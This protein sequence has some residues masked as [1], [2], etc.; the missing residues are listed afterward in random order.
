V[1]EP[2]DEALRAQLDLPEGQGAVVTRVLPG[3]VAEL[4]GLRKSDILLDV[5]GKKIASPESAK[6]LI[7]RESRLT[8]VRK[9][10]KES[11]GGRKDF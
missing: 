6:G 5:D 10:K 11:L 7:T 8:V 4:L 9:G 1:L 3:G 2:V